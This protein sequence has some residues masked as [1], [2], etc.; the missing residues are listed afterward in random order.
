MSISRTEPP[1][2]DREF[3][4]LINRYRRNPSDDE[5]GTEAVDLA[6]RLRSRLI[7]LATIKADYSPEYEKRTQQAR[8][9]IN[10]AGH[11]ADELLAREFGSSAA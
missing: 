1:D 8:E 5:L 4:A 11:H 9:L 3:I 6:Y 7:D 10:L 2:L